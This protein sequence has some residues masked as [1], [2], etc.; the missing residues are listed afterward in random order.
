MMTYHHKNILLLK[1]VRKTKSNVY[2]FLSFCN[3]KDLKNF[4]EVKGEKIDL[5]T[6]QIIFRHIA[7]GIVY[8]GKK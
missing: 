5:Y 4:R 1:D 3:G 6:T 2:M 7:E 8:L